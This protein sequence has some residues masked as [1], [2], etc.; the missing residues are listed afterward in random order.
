MTE[1]DAHKW[2][3]CVKVMLGLTN[4]DTELSKMAKTQYDGDTMKM[5]NDINKNFAEV[6][7]DLSPLTQQKASS[8]IVPDK[9]II[10]VDEVEQKL[11]NIKV[12]K[13]IGPDN[14]PNWVL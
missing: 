6:S 2:W 14:V 5:A 4:K 7:S 12:R 8:S 9:Y 3:K 1:T 11:Y 10:P 13:A